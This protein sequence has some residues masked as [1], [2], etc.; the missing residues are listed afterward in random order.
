MQLTESKKYPTTE[1]SNL[2]AERWKIEVK[3]RDIKTT[4]KFEEIRVRTPE[5]ARKTLRMIQL[6]YNLIKARQRTAT[7]GSEIPIDSVS[8]KST[9]DVLIE[10]RTAFSGLLT[11]PRKLAAALVG[12][13]E[14]IGERI[15]RIRPNRSEP[16]AVKRRPKPFPYLTSPRATY[17]EIQ[18]RSRY[19]KIS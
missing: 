14:K 7:I 1:L 13:E 5:M 17:V 18:H 3:F 19:R 10:F 4:L 8:F 12:L 16:R 6:T 2:Y 9:V 15:L 11:R